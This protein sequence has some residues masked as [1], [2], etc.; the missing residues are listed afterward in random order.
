VPLDRLARDLARAGKVSFNGFLL[1][2]A[3]DGLEL[4]LFPDGRA[5]IKGT[6]DPEVARGFYARYVGS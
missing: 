6:N 5:L 2:F 1:Q 4:V 3:A